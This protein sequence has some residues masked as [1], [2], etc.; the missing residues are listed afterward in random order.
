MNGKNKKVKVDLSE[1]S[2]LNDIRKIKLYT[3]EDR[4][5]REIK[6]EI[7]RLELDWR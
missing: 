2:F 6:T 7:G 3:E 5:Y 4:Y 1:D